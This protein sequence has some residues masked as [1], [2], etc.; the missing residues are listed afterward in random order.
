M[1]RSP[2]IKLYHLYFH[3]N[4]YDFL[5]IN[6]IDFDYSKDEAVKRFDRLY[7]LVLEGQKKIRYE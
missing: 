3:Q 4:Y 1:R 7:A 6:I 5:Q 2:K